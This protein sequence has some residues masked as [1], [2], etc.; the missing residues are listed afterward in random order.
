MFDAE[1]YVKQA[2]GAFY[3][4]EAVAARVKARIWSHRKE[5][6]VSVVF[7]NRDSEKIIKAVFKRFDKLM[8]KIA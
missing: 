2:L 1:N 8:Q 4:S 7:V 5:S 3:P 6:S